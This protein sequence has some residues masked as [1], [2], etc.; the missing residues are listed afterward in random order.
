MNKKASYLYERQF[1]PVSGQ[2]RPDA[3]KQEFWTKNLGAEFFSRVCAHIPE[4]QAYIQNRGYDV[5]GIS[6]EV[7]PPKGMEEN[8]QR[9]IRIID[10]FIQTHQSAQFAL[11]YRDYL[12]LGLDYDKTLQEALHRAPKLCGSYLCSLL[13][14]L[15]NICIRTLIY[16]LHMCKSRGELK[17]ENCKEEYEFFCRRII[18]SEWREKL[19]EKYPVLKRSTYEV[20]AGCGRL[21]LDA[22]DRLE[23]DR[24]EIQMLLCGGQ[25]FAHVKNITGDIADSH[26]GGQ[27]VLKVHLDN[28]CTVIYKPHPIDNEENFDKLADYVGKSCGIPMQ[29]MPRICRADYGWECCAKK[30]DC[31][32]GAEVRRFYQ[33]IGVYIFIFYLLGTNDIHEENVIACGEYPVIVDLENILGM[34]ENTECSNMM[35]RMKLYLQ[36]SVLYSG[37]LPAAKWRQDGKTIN[38]SGIGGGE[39]ARLPF[40]IPVIAGAG[41]SDIRIVYQYPELEP[42]QNTPVYQGNPVSP[43][44][45]EQEILDGFTKAYRFAMEHSGQ[46]E[47]Q[48]QSFRCAE[49]RYL[50]TD[51]Q[52]Y[53]MCLNSS[54]HPSLMRDGGDRQLYLYTMCYGRDL[55]KPGVLEIIQSETVDL[56]MHDIPYFYF[57]GCDRHLYNS[58]DKPVRNYF[59]QTAYG[60]MTGRLR[61]LCEPDRRHQAELIHISLNIQKEIQVNGKLAGMPESGRDVPEREE[62]LEL[63]ERMMEKILDRAVY[64]GEE[65]GW[66]VVNVAAFGAEGWQIEPMHMYL[67]GGV[68]GI[69]LLSHMLEKYTGRERY[70][71]LNRTLDKQL[72]SYTAQLEE[73]RLKSLRLGIYN[74]E[75]SIVYGY[76]CLYRLTGGDIYLKYACRHAELVLPAAGREENCDLLDGLAGVIWGMLMLYEITGKVRYLEAAREAGDRLRRKA[77]HMEEGAGWLINGEERPLLG[78]SHGNAGIAAALAKLYAITKEE[79]YYELLREALAYEN[80]YYSEELQNW[81]DFRVKDEEERGRTDTAAWCHGAGGILASRL[82]MR[83][84]VEE[85]LRETVEQDIERAGR[86]LKEHCLREGMCLCHGSCGNVLLLMEYNSDLQAVKDYDAY[87]RGKLLEDTYTFLAQ[88]QYNPGLMNGFGGVVY[89][90]LKQYDK[91]LFNVLKLD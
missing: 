72:F 4:V 16:E 49:S 38:V 10:K 51:T 26:R 27:S 42:M 55:E 68:M 5:P 77:C 88:E 48:L 40:K 35:E 57:R 84:R 52:R 71:A 1:Y 11:F 8:S 12:R 34:P 14:K 59:R 9:N 23:T 79:S 41:T 19:E 89:Y 24:E 56:S 70:T 43:E 22:L 73:M 81:L 69:A 90:L 67:Y 3:K 64:I 76:L 45:Y 28:G 60:L 85:D 83:R 2:L 44:Q 82:M 53:S 63:A 7:L 65:P 37:M 39:K 78:M 36:T 18:S 87:I 6:D 21:Y 74:G 80:H 31:G 33:R 61:G 54:Y 29:G 46:L 66:Y 47:G 75:M 91:S 17:G 30:K 58:Q 13:R 25:P 62:Y 20:I 15:E 32:S 86:K 50:L